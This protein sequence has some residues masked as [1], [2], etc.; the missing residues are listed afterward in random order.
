MFF[1][2]YLDHSRF[3]GGIYGKFY[4]N[5]LHWLVGTPFP[6]E[7]R[8]NIT[9]FDNKAVRSDFE[10]DR[11]SQGQFTYEGMTTENIYELLVNT[12]LAEK[13]LRNFPQQFVAVTDR[14]LNLP[15]EEQPW[16]FGGISDEEAANIVL[17]TFIIGNMIIRSGPK[18][19]ENL[20]YYYIL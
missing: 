4:T 17:G 7:N 11:N 14:A 5:G 12:S 9:Y 8:Y 2:Q 13:L 6:K 3:T 18:K 10:I 15:Y 19:T 20:K 1:F 16:F